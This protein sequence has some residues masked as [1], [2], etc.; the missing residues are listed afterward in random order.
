MKN[1]YIFSYILS[2]LIFVI[3]I[4]GGSISEPLFSMISAK[5]LTAAGI[6]RSS[7]DSTD[8]K[9][10]NLVYSVKRFERQIEKLKKLF[11]DDKV[12]ESKYVKKKN[13]ILLN[14]IYNPLIEILNYLYRFGFLLTSIIILL[15]GII[16]NLIYKSLELRRRVK[17]LEEV[18]YR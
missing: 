17:R 5:T 2:G 7:I 11:S 4:T 6:D 9:I 10:D 13:K 12:D 18:V 8:S 1:F 3:V 16:F 14:T 15:L